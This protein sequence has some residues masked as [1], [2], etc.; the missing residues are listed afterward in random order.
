MAAAAAELAGAYEEWQPV[1]GAYFA[2]RELYPLAWAE[3]TPAGPGLALEYARAVGA[4]GG[5]A[6]AAFRDEAKV[7]LHL[8][9]FA[10]PDVRLFDGAGEPLGRVP[11]D[12]ARIAA[13]GWTRGEELLVVDERGGAARF[14]ARGAPGAGGPP[15]SLGAAVEA[16]GVALVDVFA[17]GV[18]ALTPA[19]ALWVVAD[20]AA[21]RPARLP[22]PVPPGAEAHAL[23]AVP[24][25][26][27]HSG[28]LEVLVAVGASVVCVDAG[29]AAPTA[30]AGGPF[31]R[32]AVSPGGRAAGFSA[33]GAVHLWARR[34]AAETARVHVADTADDMEDALGGYG[35]GSEGGDGSGAAPP[36]GPPDAMAW[37]GEDGVLLFWERVGALLVGAAGGARWW[38]LGAPAAGVLVPEV[39]GVRVLTPAAHALIRRVP[40]PLASVLEPGSTSPGALL[41]DAR[42]LY[43]ARDARAATELLEVLHAG[44]LPAAVAACV[45]AAEAELDPA[46][47][48]ALL[49]AGCYGRAFLAL[50]DTAAAAPPGPGLGPGDA[51]RA[52]RRLRVLNSL[53]DAAGVAMP[54][55]APQ[56]DALGADALAARLGARGAYLLALRAAEALGGS[57]SAV[58]EA[59]ARDKVTAA[60]GRE[61]DAELH[62]ALRAKLAGRP[63]VRWARVA[64]HAAAQGRRCLA[65]ALL[66]HEL[67]AAEQVP[68][69]LELGQEEAAL[70]KGLA[71]GDGD[72]AFG[73]ANAMRQRAARAPAGSAEAQ[74]LWAALGARPAA[75][76]L[77]RKHLRARG[78]GEELR[79]AE[80]LGR[81]EDAAEAHLRAAAAAAARGGA[82]GEAEVRAEL[83]RARD[84]FARAERDRGRDADHFESGAAA[85]ALRLREVQAELQA[86]TGRDA[87]LGLSAAGTVR[88]CLRLGLREPAARVAREFKIPDKQQALLGV[89]VTAAAH[90]WA[91]LERIAA[92]LDRRSPIVAEDVVDAAR[93]AGAPPAALRA[94]ADAVAGD[95]ALVRRARMYAEMGLASEAAELV[96]QAEAAGAG[97]GMLAGL[98]DVVGGTMGS[99]MGRVA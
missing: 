23:A 64:A 56:L 34:L 62:A 95:N 24:P 15:F 32:L 81:A 4:P 58:L 25:A 71:A 11:W 33:G 44:D 39:D 66:E 99:L 29:G 53:R 49:R 98:R 70:D 17:D 18:A 73:V 90:D 63:G 26:A 87:F 41:H 67:D 50:D 36:P 27:S 96:E 8:A 2:R 38:D 76:A 7:A 55:T 45:A 12:G 42:R 47:Q 97:A 93:A 83:G 75:A 65:A 68:L 30:A 48:E 1:G 43:E 72:L 74:R 80:A 77:V 16:A 82:A 37:C 94:L 86:S 52:A 9:A 6:L 13:A 78:A 14:S 5:G 69:L 46:R 20:A 51:A 85:A 57:A 40:A 59:W 31:L 35:S 10:R 60:A 22:D 91:A 84:A 21:P 92:R 88:Q 54:L 79:M 89:A 61:G 3:L 28:A 19:G